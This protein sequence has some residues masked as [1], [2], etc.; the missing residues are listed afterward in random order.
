MAVV[1]EKIVK[2]D[3]ELGFDNAVSR[4]APGGG[5]MTGSKLHGFSLIESL[6]QTEITA[7]AGT[8]LRLVYN[9]TTKKLN[10]YNG[11]AWTEICDGVL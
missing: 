4:T 6:T 11:S 8:D 9:S 1:Y 5:T 7:I 10:F 2:E 3:L